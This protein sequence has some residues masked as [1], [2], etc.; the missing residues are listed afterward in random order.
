MT[1]SNECPTISDKCII[2][3]V[4]KLTNSEDDTYY[5]GSTIKSLEERLKEHIYFATNSKNI[6]KMQKHFNKIGWDKVSIEL[7]L[8]VPVKFEYEIRIHENKY[9]CKNL[10]Y[11]NC[12]N[13][14]LSYY[15]G[16]LGLS[17]SKFLE[18]PT[19][20]IIQMEHD[21]NTKMYTELFQR[22]NKLDESDKNNPELAKKYDEKLKNYL[23]KMNPQLSTKNEDLDQIEPQKT[24]IESQKTII[25]PEKLQIIENKKQ[26]NIKK[27]K[28]NVKNID[29]NQNQENKQNILEIIKKCSENLDI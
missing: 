14:K 25:E 23:A 12:L 24:I 28:N 9:I 2:G 15:Y 19:E 5:F 27:I 3:R 6:S 18:T 7:I 21:Y 29:K 20:Q 26:I 10:I 1:N 11:I 13:A 17:K 4:Y 22:K 8:E 16:H